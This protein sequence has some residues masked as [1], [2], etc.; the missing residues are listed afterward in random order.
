MKVLAF[1]VLTLLTQ[2]LLTN[3]F[4]DLLREGVTEMR[5]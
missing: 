5:R 2:Q 4:M 3:P 1:A